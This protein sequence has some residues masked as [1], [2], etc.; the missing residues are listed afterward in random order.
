MVDYLIRQTQVE[1]LMKQVLKQ[2]FRSKEITKDEYKNILKKA[3]PQ[4]IFC[5]FVVT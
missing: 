4:V 2:Y 5:L 1:D 3:V